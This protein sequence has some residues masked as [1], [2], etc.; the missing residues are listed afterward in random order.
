[1]TTAEKTFTVGQFV[2]GIK[3]AGENPYVHTSYNMTKGVVTEVVSADCIK[4]RAI[5]GTLPDET[6]A[7]VLGF[8]INTETEFE[9]EPKYFVALEADE[10]TDES[11]VGERKYQVGDVV[12]VTSDNPHFSGA[13]KGQDYVV[14]TVMADGNVIILEI[15]NRGGAVAPAD[16][17]LVKAVEDAEAETESKPERIGWKEALTILEADGRVLIEYQEVLEEVGALDAMEDFGIYDFDDLIN[18]ARFYKQA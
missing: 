5:E 13:F 18:I 3:V 10:P 12:Q 7:S 6:F 1:M 17:I 9:V 15:P 11:T 16:L 14:E 8:P 2:K 4:V